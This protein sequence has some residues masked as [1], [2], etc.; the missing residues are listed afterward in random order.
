MGKIILIT[1]SGRGIGK[2]AAISL[3]KRGHRVIAATHYESDAKS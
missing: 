2:Q 3:A 1:G